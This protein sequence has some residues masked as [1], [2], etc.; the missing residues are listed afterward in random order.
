M[1]P[2]GF[3]SSQKQ[4]ECKQKRSVGGGIDTN[5][6]NNHFTSLTDTLQLANELMCCISSEESGEPSEHVQMSE[7]K[8]KASM[9]FRIVYVC[10]CSLGAAGNGPPQCRLDVIVVV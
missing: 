1:T 7:Q 6:I 9:I 3:Q 2:L 10:R 5:G 8:V 4:R